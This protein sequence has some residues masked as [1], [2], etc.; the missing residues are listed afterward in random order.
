ME[1]LSTFSSLSNINVDFTEPDVTG[2][3][4]V[5]LA[6][7]RGN[8]ALLE[9]MLTELG[10]RSAAIVNTPDHNRR[11]ALHYATQSTRAGTVI[12]LLHD[13]GADFHV[14]DV[15]GHSVLQYAS[16]HKRIEAVRVA[17]ELS[18]Q[19]KDESVIRPLPPVNSGTGY[20]V[21]DFQEKTQQHAKQQRDCTRSEKRAG[22]RIFLLNSLVKR[23][24]CLR[25]AK[26]CLAVLL[27]SCVLLLVWLS[28]F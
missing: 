25:L 2:K 16:E 4:M 1:T 15:N 19:I 24:T 5:H 13:H 18:E 17:L 20:Q 27:S 21:I 6:A 22:K 23:S 10:P 9:H 7:Q 26:F 14:L 8:I 28:R 11:T 3:S 12:K